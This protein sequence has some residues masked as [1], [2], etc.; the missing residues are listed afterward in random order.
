MSLQ[1]TFIIPMLIISG[2]AFGLVSTVA[3]A[4]RPAQAQTVTE[5]Q[6]QI[7]ALTQ[8]VQALMARIGELEG[9]GSG[10]GG[11]PTTSTCPYTW[12]RNLSIGMSGDDVEVLQKFLNG[13]ADTVIAATGFGSPGNETTY[14]GSATAN[15]VS[16]FQVKYR[17]DILSP[18]G[19]VNP[20]GRFDAATR[21]KANALCLSGTED[22]D[23]DDV[24]V[25]TTRLATIPL[26]ETAMAGRDDRI[27][28]EIEVSS[29]QAG[30]YIDSLMIGMRS[31]SGDNNVAPFPWDTFSDVSLWVN[32]D[33]VAE[34]PAGSVN[35]WENRD[36]YGSDN[37]LQFT[38][39]AIPINPGTAQIVIAGSIKATAPVG[40]WKLSA[41]KLETAANGS[42][43]REQL[44]S[45][46]PVLFRVVPE[47]ADSLVIRPSSNDPAAST[48]YFNEDD[49]LTV[50]VFAFELDATESSYD[51]EL[52]DLALDFDVTGVA[53]LDIVDE[54][55]LQVA[56]EIIVPDR[57]STVGDIFTLAID[58]GDIV[59]AAGSSETVK[60]FVITEELPPA[61]DGTRMSVS[62]EYAIGEGFD[63]VVATG[64]AVGNT[65]TF[66]L[67]N[68][69]SSSASIVLEAR[70]ETKN[71]SYVADSLTIDDGDQVQLRWVT[72]GVTD[73]EL[74][75][76]RY[77]TPLDYNEQ[78]EG[79]NIQE[80]QV[81]Q[82]VT[83][84]LRCDDPND[85]D[86][87]TEDITIIKRSI[88]NDKPYV[89]VSPLD[90]SATLLDV[91]SGQSGRFE[92][93][94]EVTAIDGDV[95]IDT[96]TQF[97]GAGGGKDGELIYDVL[98]NGTAQDDS[99]FVSVTGELSSTASKSSGRYVI[100][101]DDTETFTLTVE[102]MPEDDGNY[103][104]RLR[105]PFQFI[106]DDNSVQQLA[107]TESSFTTDQI[108]IQGESE[109][110]N[111][112]PGYN[113]MACN[114]PPSTS[115]NTGEVVC[116]GMWDL[117]S[118]FGGD[119]YE[120]GAN[121]EVGDHYSGYG[122]GC[123]IQIS[124]CESGVAEAT[125]HYKPASESV[126]V[127]HEAAENLGVSDAVAAQSVLRMWEYTCVPATGDVLGASTSN[128]GNQI[129]ALITQVKALLAGLQ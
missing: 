58:G 8:L 38:S 89:R 86:D 99:E 62:V 80:P 50:S 47:L 77:A 54:V 94:F 103:Q 116:Y 109:L 128:L 112:A 31:S 105:S 117:N 121:G 68:G 72:E 19:L 10:G 91:G 4:P 21:A 44:H 111:S 87:I 84:T 96:A 63:D 119:H 43:V 114:N 102:V 46:A 51:I 13:N 67:I 28:F 69:E 64:A 71:T 59:I 7:A 49:E 33:K 125:A 29:T 15:A 3:I 25:G 36:E 93:E 126:G 120:C 40:A 98:M 110:M 5:L 122:T 56:G 61:V 24:A 14:Y 78:R 85:T 129:T 88:V 39:L 1:R 53:P 97:S 55:E 73:C 95:Y 113:R 11:T 27:L 26:D 124:A 20:T 100:D 34:R 45:S 104:A 35:D 123:Q 2:L 127:L 57:L 118:D 107:I 70:N 75:D 92:I 90:D 66:R 23:P 48:F 76:P 9:T 32:G 115:V 6:A 74:V 12:E 41:Q 108:Y 79:A 106:L 52:S 30:R 18:L 82:S 22:E 16:K 37:Y 81:G 65:H 83:L 42:S 60:V 101:E 17:S